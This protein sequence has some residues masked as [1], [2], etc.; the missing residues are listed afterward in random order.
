[1]KEVN[2]AAVYR[3]LAVLLGAY[4]SLSVALPGLVLLAARETGATGAGTPHAV[5]VEYAMAAPV[6]SQDVDAGGRCATRG[7]G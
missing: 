7:G 3:K 4:V 6:D 1:M 5:G 2:R